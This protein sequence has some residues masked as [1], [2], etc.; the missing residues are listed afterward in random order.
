MHHLSYTE[1]QVT[2]MPIEKTYAAQLLEIEKKIQLYYPQA[3]ISLLYRAFEFAYEKHADQKRASGEPYITHPL[4]VVEILVGLKTDMTSI[5]AGML[6]DVI[7]DTPATAEDIR[8]NFG[9]EVVTLVQG[10]TK[11]AR[12]DFQSALNKQ[13][14]N[15]RKFVLAVANDIRVLLIKV[16]D[17]LHNM[18]TLHHI[19][20]QENRRRVAAET[21]E[22]YAPLAERIGLHL[23][24]EELQDIAFKELYPDVYA[25][26]K[27]QLDTVY[28]SDKKTIHL[29]IKD[30]EK[31]CQKFD[32]RAEVMGRKKKPYAIWKKMKRKNI[33]FEQLS[34]IIAFRI[35]V[36]S[37]AD[38]YQV[39]GLIHSEYFVVPNRF[40]D[41]ISTPKSNGYQS[42]HT[43]VIAPDQRQIEIQIRTFGMQQVAQYG[44][45]SHW[46]YKQGVSDRQGRQYKWVR[47]LLEVLD[48]ASGSVEFLEN[49][50]I[51]MFQDQVFC[52]TPHGDLIE[53]PK[54][55]TVLDFAYA[56]HSDL[57]H[58][59][60]GA[61]INGKLMPLRTELKNGDQIEILVSHQQTPS[62]TW[63]RFVVTAK[64]RSSIRR[65]IRSKRQV[66]FQGLG[67]SIFAKLLH[68][69]GLT[70]DKQGQKN[71]L[72]SFRLSSLEDFYGQLGEGEISLQEL[73]SFL[74][75]QEVQE[76]ISSKKGDCKKVSDKK[77]SLSGLMSGVVVHYAECCHPLPG[78][79]IMGIF[80]KKGVTVHLNV[81]KA[82]ETA[83]R[84][85]KNVMELSWGKR[86]TSFHIVRLFI[87]LH[88]RPGSLGILSTIL[89]ERESNIH[90]LKITKRHEE[91][92]D[93]FID[94][95]V[96]SMR[97]LETIM[98]SLRSNKNINLVERV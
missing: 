43:Q 61:K 80:S 68:N 44:I 4:A 51:E 56:V 42:L 62:S 29:M 46:Q 16:A 91:F 38:C 41:Y 85:G 39:L 98:A 79:K 36:D 5:V 63:S 73:T 52:F 58:F 71:L 14:E 48:H 77:S 53:L 15:F 95:S 96:K 7:E 6:H 92:F 12:I 47:S 37:V 78:E 72:A 70:L 3:D 66:Q 40:K 64:A 49:T 21:L 82:L 34:D 60:K 18:R 94:I 74:K 86:Q 11:L 28:K 65:F 23:I 83:K 35:L 69:V 27:S 84:N 89:G 90:N 2:K 59:C 93:L 87:T 31:I 32:I 75:N 22:I 50:K 33:S 57:G 25:N 30:L 8:Q 55:A 97:H 10:V 54:G 1:G 19:L 67:Q 20:L 26:I 9:D 88:N 13:A 24:Q 17:R 76:K 45:A 81:C